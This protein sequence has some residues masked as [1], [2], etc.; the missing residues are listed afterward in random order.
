M[1]CFLRFSLLVAFFG[2]A[3]LGV[4]PFFPKIHEEALN[5]YKAWEVVREAT[6]STAISASQQEEV[7]RE[8]EL[9]SLSE[10]QARRMLAEPKAINDSPALKLSTDPLIV[11]ARR[12]AKL[13]P[14]AAMLWLQSR[15]AGADR[16]RGMLEVVAIWAADDSESTLLWLESNAQ[17]IA[18][19]ETLQS[20]INL[21]AETAPEA[22]ADWIDGMASDGSKLTAAKSLAAKWVESDPKAAAKWVTN[23]PRGPI[24][25]EAT[26]A[27]TNAWLE[28]DPKAASIWAFQEAEFNGYHDLLNETIHAFSRRYPEDAE[29]L[30]REMASANNSS[31]AGVEA[32][33]RARAEQ[34]PANTAQ[35][36]ANLAMSDPIYSE[37]NNSALMQVWAVSDS[38]AA[39]EWLSQ[40]PMGPQRD[41][42]IAGFCKSIERFEPEAATIWANSMGDP[43][44]RVERLEESLSNWADLR[45]VEAL[46]W[47]KSTEM[48]PGLREQLIR[49]IPED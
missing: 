36:L 18:R 30:V 38:I 8:N 21:W 48:E 10:K 7:Q 37:E 3:A 45:P 44:R 42:A 20:G 4:W 27:L 33:I 49:K 24:R 14:E 28:Q 40:M 23:L 15:N 5:F 29:A 31:G 34:D 11:E 26:H 41:S 6:E 1:R 12:R 32:H 47:L 43:I 39:S 16:L 25:L 13:D 35:W 9:D 22:A 19:L 46:E 17:G 2:V